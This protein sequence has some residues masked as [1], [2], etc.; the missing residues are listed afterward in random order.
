MMTTIAKGVRTLYRATLDILVYKTIDKYAF[1]NTLDV[2]Y[3]VKTYYGYTYKQIGKSLGRLYEKEEIWQCE[4]CYSPITTP[5]RWKKDE[6]VHHWYCKKCA[7]IIMGA[8]Q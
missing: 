4:L 5:G 1:K 3:H 2:M 6:K 7:S 8:V